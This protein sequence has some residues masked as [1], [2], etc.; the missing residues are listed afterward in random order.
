VRRN[1]GDR[2]SGDHMTAQAIFDAVKKNAS[3]MGLKNIAQHDLRRSFAKIALKGKAP[4]EQ[5]QISLGHTWSKQ[6][7]VILACGRIYRMHL[8]ATSESICRFIR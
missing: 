2:I 4:L 8:V 6:P 7:S 3:E 1:K 5:I